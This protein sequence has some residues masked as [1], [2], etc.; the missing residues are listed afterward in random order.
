MTLGLVV[1]GLLALVACSRPSGTNADTVTT[2]R[3]G[4]EAVL[5]AGATVDLAFDAG[6][7]AELEAEPIES[8]GLP[9]ALLRL[10]LETPS[11]EP[12]LVRDLLPGEATAMALS[13]DERSVR[14]RLEAFDACAPTRVALRLAAPRPA[15]EADHRQWHF[16]RLRAAAVEAAATE[17]T[18]AD[19]PIERAIAAALDP[20]EPEASV[21]R[22]EDL[23][24]T[25][26]SGPTSDTA[27]RRADAMLRTVYARRLTAEAAPIE[28][29]I[30]AEN[31]SR[32]AQ[33]RG[34]WDEAAG[35]L[36]TAIA[37]R[38]ATGLDAADD[39]RRFGHLLERALIEVHR[40]R[41]SQAAGD[42]K[43]AESI[44]DA[45]GD[46]LARAEV[47]H[48]LG[49]VLRAQGA[50]EQAAARL[51]AG[52]ADL[53]EAPDADPELA[54]VLRE[55]RAG[56][57]K[58]LGR[59]DR[60]VE[61]LDAIEITR[62]RSLPCATGSRDNAVSLLNRAE[63]R[64][65]QARLV[66]AA[67]DYSAALRLA[68]RPRLGCARA[69]RAL[70]ATQ[71]AV[72]EAE[73]GHVA[74]AEQLL[75]EARSSSVSPLDRARVDLE[76]AALLCANGEHARPHRGLDAA[77]AAHSLRA[78]TLGSEHPEVA[79]A[80]LAM[81]RCRHRAGE[82][83]PLAEVEQARA[84]LERS[85][86]E[87]DALID[88]L[89]L[90]SAL[91]RA[92][93][94]ERAADEALLR[95]LDAADALR[96]TSGGGWT[97]RSE[98]LAR[99]LDV[100]DR[101]VEARVERGEPL[102][103]LAASERGRA[104][105]LAER[106][107]RPVSVADAAAGDPDLAARATAARAELAE[108][109][110]R[111]DRE[112][113]AG[114]WQ[115][116][117]RQEA[118]AEAAAR[119]LDR[120]RGRRSTPSDG[121]AP[122]LGE[123]AAFNGAAA[124]A[125]RRASLGPSRRAVI[126]HVGARRSFVFVLGGVDEPVD[127]H[128][129]ASADGGPVGRAQ[130]RAAIDEAPSLE[131]Q[132][133]AAGTSPHGPLARRLEDLAD[134]LVPRQVANALSDA[135]DVLLVADPPLDAV[136]FVALPWPSD[137]ADDE[138]DETAAVDGTTSRPWL[139]AGPALVHTP[140]LAVAAA[141]AQDTSF[142]DPTAPSG[143]TALLVT[144]DGETAGPFA[145]ER[146]REAARRALRRLGATELLARHGAAATERNVRSDLG[147][148][149]RW[150][151]AFTHGIASRG[152][153][154]TLGALVLQPGAGTPDDDGRLL[155]HEI[156]TLDLD[157]EVVI[158][159]ACSGGVGR[160]IAGEGADSLARSFLAAGARRVIASRWP[161]Q[162]TATESFVTE[163]FNAVA[164]DGDWTRALRRAQ[165]RTRDRHGGVDRWAPF[166]V[167]GAPS[168]PSPDRDSP[169]ALASDAGARRGSQ[170]LPSSTSNG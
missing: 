59:L 91:L 10:H 44:A 88:A 38:A 76:L 164:D 153:S 61:A 149:P 60:A 43:D 2:L 3:P 134:L 13:V 68:H 21:D 97:T 41:L 82:A 107:R 117:A 108:A 8:G 144:T 105:S 150:I 129:L 141:L 42:L 37:H 123:A 26:F 6:G 165:R 124:I 166:Y 96:V 28:L 116:A 104:R 155:A 7:T 146:A 46:P 62:R 27:C 167:L 162:V 169:D 66:E 132:I 127:V 85:G 161:V 151:F 154:G 113:E 101:L 158:L 156:D 140:S 48:Q 77:R 69:D 78:E 99:H 34:A 170:R 103:A 90:E 39:E 136:P 24:F 93:G 135:G 35:W 12:L 70:F 22:L 80:T 30:S 126:Y 57:W 79:I 18:D 71:A 122:S 168:G 19:G 52:L 49:E 121:P 73:R 17:A 110:L 152:A 53:A 92:A 81:A 109:I 142:C 50:F 106:I 139:D 94:R 23:A 74:A 33:D 157:A 58:D 159:A 16:E 128:E 54:W 51:D 102:L 14:L 125:L 119:R 84:V 75:I 20:L 111:R 98:V 56:L 45:W 114:R 147:R 32:L 118:A 160:P 138:A 115:Q 63:I 4:E 83:Q 87:P 95:A 40:G 112:R 145:G 15:T 5:F 133:A 65:L 143:A 86:L 47:A 55:S 72:L 9:P 163:L 89:Q 36:E 25:L 67:D 100:V 11:G 148:G 64:R 29:M 131:L 137:R 31:L 120:L 1:L 130:L